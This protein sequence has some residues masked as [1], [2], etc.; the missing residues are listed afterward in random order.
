MTELIFKLF[1]NQE[2]RTAKSAGVFAGSSDDLRDGF[3]HFSTASQVRTT[4]DRYFSHEHNPILAAVD[5]RALGE[6]LKWEIS[7]GGETFPHLYRALN[8]SEVHSACEIARDTNGRPIF[9][10]EIL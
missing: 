10:P 4:Y 1:R 3:L 2:W 6:A 5:A 7:R 8:V 9:P